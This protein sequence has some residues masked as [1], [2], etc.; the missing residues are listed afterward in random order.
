[1]SELS[2]TTGTG[3]RRVTVAATD[4]RIDL[5]LAEDMPVAEIYPELL[6]L[7]GQTQAAGTPTGYHLVRADGTLLDP[8]L[9]L[10]AQRVVDGERLTLRP[11]DRSLPPAVFDSVSDAVASAVGRDRRLW[12]DGL[13]RGA[14]LLGSV[15]LLVL[16]SYLLWSADPARHDMNGLPGVVAGAAGVL[17]TAFAGARA[18]AYGDRAGS[19]AFGLAAL[20]MLLLAG[21]GIV[22]PDGG[23][24]PGRLQFLLGCVCM[25]VASSVLLALSPGGSAPF[26]GAVFVTAAGTLASFV[27]ILTEAS[28]TETASVCVPIAVGLI[29]F[30]PGL[31]SRFARLPIGYIAPR[32]AVDMFGADPDPADARQAQL[33]AE[34]HPVGTPVDAEQVAL[35]ARRSHELL[36]GLVGGCAVVVAVAAGV[37]GFSD[38]V[39]AQFLALAAGLSMLLRAR[40]FRYTA[41]VASALLAGIASI[42][43]LLAGLATNP[44]ADLMNELLRYGDR[45]GLDIR[46]MWLFALGAAGVALFTAIGLIVPKKGL[47]PFWGRFLDLAESAVLLSLL[48]LCLATL[49]LFEAARSVTS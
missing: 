1:M 7:T 19:V 39:W 9:T 15:L 24:G 17:L 40:L 48:P 37:L 42:G 30:L 38:S 3:F 13:L 16:M 49:E 4:N 18:R 25:L 47:T 32:S 22:G 14:S 21:S 36:L 43:L 11:M 10:A 33:T 34:V 28:A 35:R 23:D 5:A 44:P 2:T 27:A 26:V 8:T 46:A 45:T 31:S 20:P 29:A 6:R 41:Q 12:S